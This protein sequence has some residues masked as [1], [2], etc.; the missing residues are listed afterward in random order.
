MKY[1]KPL[2]DC[3]NGLVIQKNA[4][5]LLEYKITAKG[6]EANKGKQVTELESNE[7][8]WLQCNH[9][10]NKYNYNFDF[11]GKDAFKIERE[12]KLD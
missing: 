6:W 8:G 9:C 4:Y 7:F 5:T 1:T 10:G 2:C 12:E 3:G 11:H